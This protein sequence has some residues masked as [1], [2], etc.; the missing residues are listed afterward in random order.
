MHADSAATD[1]WRR[2]AALTAELTTAEKTAF[3][4]QH[5]PAV[6]RLGLAPFVTGTEAAHGV[7]W[8]GTATVFPQPVGL[9]ATWD[10]ELVRRVGEAVGVELRAKHA[11][12][13][14]VSLNAWSPVVNPL[15]NPRWGRNEE[16]FSEDPW[17]TAELATA[18]ARGLRG[19][20]PT[21]WRTVP[22]LKHVLG[23]NNETDRDVSSSTMRPRVLHEYEL[24]A[25]AGPLAAGVVGALMPAYNLVNGRPAHV[26]RELLDL[27]RA[28]APLP[29]LVVSDA[30]APSN[31]AGSQRH[32]P[33][34]VSSHAAA[35]RAGVDSFT[36]GGADAGPTVERLTAALDAELVTEADLDRAVTRLLHLRLLT[37][38][39][40]PA[41]DPYAGT[42]A[43]DLDTP[44]HRV[45]A[46]EAATRS[47][48]LLADPDRLLPLPPAASVA[49]VGPFADRVLHDWYSGTPPY[50]VGLAEALAES[51][52]VRTAAG[53][54]VV[55]LRSTTTGRYVRLDRAS[56]GLVA[57]GTAPDAEA[58]FT[59]D[60]WGRGTCTLT[61]ADGRL[62]TVEGGRTLRAAATRVGGWEVQESFTLDSSG[63]GRCVLRH[64]GSRSWVR[65]QVGTDRLEAGAADL[66]DAERFVLSTVTSGL[67]A[68]AE[69][70]AE[71]EVV[72]VTAGNEPHLWGRET[73]DRPDLVLAERQREILRTAR[74]ANPRCVL[75][76]VSSYP[77]VLDP[78]E[79]DGAAVLWSS[80]GGQEL[81]HG[82]AAVLRGEEEPTGRLAQAWP[83]DPDAAPDLF[84][85]DVI[86]SRQTYGYDPAAARYPFGHGLGYTEVLWGPAAVE[87]GALPAGPPAGGP[88]RV[89][90]AL[91]NPGPR[92]TTEVVQVYARH[93]CPGRLVYPVR[94]VGHTRVVLEPGATQDVTMDVD[95]ARLAVWDVRVG[96]FA[97][98]PGAHELLVG[99]SVAD[100][101]SRLALEVAGEPAAPTALAT[102]LLRAVDFD[103]HDGV[104][105]VP[106]QL[107]AGEAIAPVR[108]R[109]RASIDFW[110]VSTA[111]ADALLLRV[112][113][114]GGTLALRHRPPVGEEAWQPL[115]GTRVDPSEDWTEV[116]VPLGPAPDVV[117]LRVEIPA[118]LQVLDLGGPPVP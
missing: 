66:G 2:A 82:L 23:Y 72:V 3:C 101:R 37:G 50:V 56:G 71:A 46:R 38:E 29:L 9:A 73:Q 104:D 105:L 31:L 5:A 24:P 26:S 51:G 12:D 91:T 25:F 60:D 64:R 98:L 112:R 84:D 22:T 114:G 97:L 85:Y 107:L 65:R 35:L 62:L 27:L 14:A 6:P 7:A 13:P 63:H 19:D 76:V 94:L 117:D 87:P 16:G 17:L 99:R 100:A 1:L 78:D 118:G 44:A 93:T 108:R 4:H 74:A 95:P 61:A 70:A 89:A 68:V 69:A 67:A 40:D 53:A 41:D 28:A 42:T 111:D 102:T 81:G 115:G 39:L 52:E 77:Y 30:Y 45:L 10:P 43:A 88:L 80:H 32:F 8:L 110:R 21:V 86:A 20:H 55:T 92:T 33:D 48:V 11:V 103:D 54:D 106:D 34:H 75:V 113:G 59:L 18:Y 109:S 47:V 49:V 90:L 83:A 96:G 57:D 79:V 58:R 116:R 15:R 36:D